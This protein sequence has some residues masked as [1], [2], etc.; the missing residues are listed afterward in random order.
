[1]I[2]ISIRR[3]GFER[4]NYIKKKNLFKNVGSNCFWQ[5]RY[6]PPEGKLIS[7]HNNVVVAAKVWFIPHDAIHYMI[8]NIYPQE[9]CGMF[10]DAIEVG[11]NVFI[12]S[13][14]TILAG[15]K[16][17]D[18]VI[19]GAGS[20]VKGHISGGGVYAGVPAK[21]I[22]NFWEFCDNRRSYHR[23]SFEAIWKDFNLKRGDR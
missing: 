15:T 7:L 17:G 6:L 8:K 22:G 12:G 3:D 1:M 5:P 16:I 19:I 13:N 14:T 2:A 20:L 9:E 21:K 23:H 11:S 10:M 4:A 18:N